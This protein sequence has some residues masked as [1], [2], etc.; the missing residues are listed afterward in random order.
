MNAPKEHQPPAVGLADILKATGCVISAGAAVTVGGVAALG[1]SGCSRD[2]DEAT[3]VPATETEAASEAAAEPAAPADPAASPAA[4]SA[5]APQGQPAAA[6]GVDATGEIEE[7]TSA[8]FIDMEAVRGALEEA[9]STDDLEI[10][11]NEIYTGEHA[12]LLRVRNEGNEQ[13]TEAWE[14]LDDNG[15]IDEANDDKLFTLVLA[16]PD[17]GGEE[18]AAAPSSAGNSTDVEARIVGHGANAHYT[19]VYPATYRPTGAF[20]TGF[21]LANLY[22]PRWGWVTPPA[23][24]VVIVNHVRAYRRTPRWA[25]RRAA[26]RSYFHRVRT[27][28]PRWHPA[29][30]RLSPARV[31][32][33]AAPP[34]PPAFRPAHPR[35]VAPPRPPRPR[36]A[37]PPPRPRFTG[38]GR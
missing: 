15:T 8:G 34:R 2:A 4:P 25:A 31:R 12:I 19:Y 33:R 24:R 3:A 22:R 38:G 5:P 29:K 20:W 11:L 30:V 36:V 16:R 18:V 13:H 7:A 27:V 32:F 9:T 10:R 6:P 21:L 14:D 35:V 28:H 23:R 17:E 37:P 1:T 26:T